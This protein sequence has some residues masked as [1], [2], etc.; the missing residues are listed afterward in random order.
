MK[1]RFKSI[2]V[3]ATMWFSHTADQSNINKKV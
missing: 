3:Y 1:L 2:C